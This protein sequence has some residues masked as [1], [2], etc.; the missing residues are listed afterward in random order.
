MKLKPG[1]GIDNLQFGM[2]PTDVEQSL[3]SPN[4]SQYDSSDDDRLL[5]EYNK[6]SLRLVFYKDEGL[7]LGYMHTTNPS[8]T[9]NDEIIIGKTIKEAIDTIFGDLNLEW[10]KDTYDYWNCFGEQT[11]WITLN[12]EYGKIKEVELGV[13]IDDNDNYIWANEKPEYNKL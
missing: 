1:I 3:G 11:Y 2:T 12:E 13:S 6:Y 7:R 9:Y 8:I 10:E 5:V 4:K